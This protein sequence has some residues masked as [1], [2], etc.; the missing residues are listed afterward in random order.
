MEV[1]K[2]IIIISIIMLL[3]TLF[4]MQYS[5]SYAST[6]SG[7][8]I[9]GADDFIKDGTDSKISSENIKKLSDN[10]YNILLIIGVVIATIVGAILGIQFITGSVEQKSKIKESLIPYFVGCVV[11]FGAF[12]IWKL[13]VILL[14]SLN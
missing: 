8:V 13:A 6:F 1:R 12:G 9:G 10:I 5:I 3:I 7:D 11:I 14:G 4:S 2:C